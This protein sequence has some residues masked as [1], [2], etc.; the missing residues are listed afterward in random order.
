MKSGSVRNNDALN[1]FEIDVDGH[2]AYMDYR[3]SPGAIT[4]TLTEVPRE[5]NGRGIG[6]ALVRG[7]L[8]AVRTDGRKVIVQCG[9]IR[10]YMAKHPEFNDLLP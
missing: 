1:R 9:F 4:L 3:L 10:A 2:K 7:A 6:S 5:L 8:E